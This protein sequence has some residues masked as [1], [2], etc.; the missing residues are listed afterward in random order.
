MARTPM[1]K[2]R[3]TDDPYMIFSG[4]FGDTKVLKAYA[5][6]DT[7][8]FARWFVA[9]NGDM[10]DTYVRDVVNYGTLLYIDPVL[11]EAGYTPPTHIGGP[12]PLQALGF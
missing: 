11:T 1:G 12:D 8:D 3:T 4:P 6:D 9:C 7:K 10:G 2:T 5:G